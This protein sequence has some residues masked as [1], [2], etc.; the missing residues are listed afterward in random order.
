[1]NNSKKIV[2]AIS[3]FSYVPILVFTNYIVQSTLSSTGELPINEQQFKLFIVSSVVA[4]YSG[5]LVSIDDAI[6]EG[7]L[8]NSWKL[9]FLFFPSIAVPYYYYK[10]VHKRSSI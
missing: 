8:T 10:N 6:K 4:I 3:L 7:N 5:V 2:L 9:A 1:M